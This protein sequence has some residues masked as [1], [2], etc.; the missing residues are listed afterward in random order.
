MMGDM[1]AKTWKSAKEL[2]EYLN[3]AYIKLHTEFE[4]LFWISSM[5]DNSVNTKKD[6]AR[7]ALSAFQSNAPL[8]E[9]VRQY[10]RN[11]KGLEKERLEYWETFF[12]T[13]EVPAEAQDLKKKITTLETKIQRIRGTRKEGY[14]DPKTKKFIKASRNAMSSLMATVDDEKVRKACFDAI[15]E[16]AKGNVANYITLV[17]LRN[18]YANLLGYQDFY[19][20]KLALEEKM[21]KKELF[22]LFDTIYEKTKYAFADIRKLEKTTPGLRKPWNFGYMMAGSF[23]KEEDQYFPFEEALSRW[24]TSFAALGITYKKGSL[25]L[26]LLDRDGKY[27]NGFCHWPE[28]VQFKGKK[29]IPGRSD[30]TCNVVLGTPG[31][32]DDGYNTLFHEGGHAAHLLNCEMP[33]VCVNS[34]YP[35]LS[36][37]WAETQSMFLDTVFSSPEWR[38]RYAKNADG[39]LYPFDLYERQL[40]ALNVTAPLFM[41]SVGM[42]C[43][44]EREIYS[45]KK[46]TEQ[47]VLAIAKKHFK[48][49]TDRSLDSLSILEVPHIYS[50]ESSCS[51]QGYGLAVLALTQWREYFYDKYGYIVDNPRVGK[52][53][54][55]VW[56]YGGSKSF[57]E[58]VKLATGK[59]LSANAHIKSATM[60]VEKKLALAKE[61][62]ATLAKKP[63]YTKKVDLDASITMVHGKQKIADNKKGFEAMSDTYAKWLKTQYKK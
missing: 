49:H 50:W 40:R 43:R 7:A 29:R 6:I 36:T 59:K 44:F 51:Y 60:P 62:I 33:D 31:E 37:A 19:D 2:L 24:G 3:S 56:K 63:K 11:T 28:L 55:A 32:S 9:T 15:Q 57:P 22:S 16:L 13:H 52:E 38:S 41:M 1:K 12:S 4:E 26:D 30:F 20:Y 17:A 42:V 39:Q 34:E 18:Q 5:G 25:T 8:L 46:L 48:L 21:T 58:F 23:I 54:A 47:R 53:M 35:P 45:T 61:R 14:I 27:N 10:K